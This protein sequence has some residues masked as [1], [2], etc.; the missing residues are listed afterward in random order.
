MERASYLVF[1]QFSRRLEIICWIHN[2][3]RW[4]SF[5]SQKSNQFFMHTVRTSYYTFITYVFLCVC[6]VSKIRKQCSMLARWKKK[7]YLYSSLTIFIIHIIEVYGIFVRY[8]KHHHYNMKKQ[9]TIVR[10]RDSRQKGRRTR[11]WWEN[12]IARWVQSSP[13]SGMV[14][15][16]FNFDQHFAIKRLL[17]ATR[18]FVNVR[19]SISGLFW[20]HV[21]SI[22]RMF[23]FSLSSL[24][25]FFSV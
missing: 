24:I 23:F 12:F 18:S 19:V 21:F 16:F 1:A 17:T 2:R 5:N 4:W 22:S 20:C 15:K 6:V 9:Q 8:T 25:S 11:R 7:T 10:Q 14:L 3:A 13:Q